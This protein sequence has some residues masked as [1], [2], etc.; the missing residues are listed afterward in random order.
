MLY[1][2]PDIAQTLAEV[3]RV[4]KPDGAMMAATNGENYMLD[5]DLLLT[6]FWPDYGGLHTMSIK[7]NLQ[8]GSD[9]LSQWFG[10]VEK[11][12]YTG[13]LWVTEAQPLV[14]YVYSTPRVQQV[15]P[16]DQREAM[17]V[18]FQARIDQAGGILIRK[19]TGLFL[20]SLPKKA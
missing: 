2:V 16:L 14:D 18:F 8:N 3:A 19:E 7:F 17:R 6:E 11:K 5:L 10:V 1:H 4:L 9:Q 15:I 12:L 20:A 13:D